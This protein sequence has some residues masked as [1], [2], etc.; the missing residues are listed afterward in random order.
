MQDERTHQERLK[1]HST[2][3]GLSEILQT[4]EPDSEGNEVASPA[5]GYLRG[6]RERGASVEFRL[7]NGT[8]I[9]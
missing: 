5:F 7:R 4:K 2:P 8:S 6:I 3:S 9:W 1:R